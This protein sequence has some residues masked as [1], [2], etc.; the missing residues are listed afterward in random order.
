MHPCMQYQF[1]T[2]TTAQHG[3]RHTSGL[4]FKGLSESREKHIHRYLDSTRRGC[5]K[6]E[7]IGLTRDGQS[8]LE[9][10]HPAKEEGCSRPGQPTQVVTELTLHLPQ[11]RSKRVP[12]GLHTAA[13]RKCSPPDVGR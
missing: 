10:W 4:C 12:L 13:S 7:T 1:S 5:M 2:I 9:S 11:M 8:I 6:L 3:H